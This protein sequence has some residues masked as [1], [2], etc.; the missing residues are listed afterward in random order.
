MDPWTVFFP[1]SPGPPAKKRGQACQQLL[2]LTVL[3]L[4][5]T[6][7]PTTTRPDG[8]G[9]TETHLTSSSLPPSLFCHKNVRVVVGG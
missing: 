2:N 4:F 1:P 3:L 6:G 7:Q 8:G 9:G 5:G